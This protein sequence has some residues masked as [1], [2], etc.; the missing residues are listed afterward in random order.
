MEYAHVWNTL[1]HSRINP[2]VSI[3]ILRK[4]NKKLSKKKRDFW[5]SQYGNMRNRRSNKK[6]TQTKTQKNHFPR[7]FFA[8]LGR[9]ERKK[10]TFEQDTHKQKLSTHSECTETSFEPI[11]DFLVFLSTSS[12][13]PRHRNSINHTY[14]THMTR[15]LNANLILEMNTLKLF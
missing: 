9:N 13:N 5:W 10:I 14:H 2:I 3:G 6:K 11:F 1:K 7:A 12:I 8:F 4:K 15:H